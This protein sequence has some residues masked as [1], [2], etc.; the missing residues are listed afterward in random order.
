L[1]EG[2]L[3]LSEGLKPNLVYNAPVATLSVDCL[4]TFLA[5]QEF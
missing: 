4:A 1:K 2:K 3:A 5:T